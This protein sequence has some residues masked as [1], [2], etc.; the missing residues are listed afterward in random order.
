MS[1]KVDAHREAIRSLGRI[2]TVEGLFAALAEYHKSERALIGVSY[3]KFLDKCIAS[4]L[5]FGGAVFISGRPASEVLEGLNY[6]VGLVVQ[7]DV[8]ILGIILIG[9]TILPSISRDSFLR[10]IAETPHDEMGMMWAEYIFLNFV[11]AFMFFL[12]FG[13]FLTALIFAGAKGSPVACLINF[14]CPDAYNSCVK[15]VLLSVAYAGLVYFLILS[16]R[17]LTRFLFNIFRLVMFM[18]QWILTEEIESETRREDVH[19]DL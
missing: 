6:V 18:H 19:K 17:K 14:A 2:K 11:N 13:V 5:L 12:K 7:F 15:R 3:S 1:K 10:V 9:F 8:T 4:A 16:Y